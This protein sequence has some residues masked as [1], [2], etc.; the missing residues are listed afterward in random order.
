MRKQTASRCAG[1]QVPAAEGHLATPACVFVPRTCS[2]TSRNPPH[3]YT[4]NSAGG[5]GTRLFTAAPWAAA[6][7]GDKAGARRRAPRRNSGTC[8]ARCPAARSRCGGASGR[9]SRSPNGPA[10]PLWEHTK[11]V[12]E[13]TGDAWAPVHGSAIHSG[14]NMEATAGP[15]MGGR[16]REVSR[17]GS[18]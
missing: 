18:G 15:L 2:P 6:N 8:P 11:P 3:G 10:S 14:R 17:R 13:Q 4:A 5:P 7:A 1:G 9:D 16:P 12:C